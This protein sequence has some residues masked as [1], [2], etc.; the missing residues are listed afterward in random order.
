LT[1]IAATR[2]LIPV[3][4]GGPVTFV[5]AHRTLVIGVAVGPIEALLSTA[6]LPLVAIIPFS[7]WTLLPSHS[8]PKP[9]VVIILAVLPTD[10]P[11]SIILAVSLVAVLGGALVA[12]LSLGAIAVAAKFALTLATAPAAVRSPVCRTLAGEP[13]LTT[14]KAGVAMFIILIPVH[15]L[16]LVTSMFVMSHSKKP[17]F[18]ASQ[19]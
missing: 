1:P 5:R 10:A 9:P 13:P 16:M 2:P 3:S 8:W 19:M 18:S 11:A 14:A 12:E 6:L 7:G 15:V 4:S 17:P